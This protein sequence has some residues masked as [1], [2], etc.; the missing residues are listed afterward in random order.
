MATEDPTSARPPIVADVTSSRTAV[1]EGE[2]VSSSNMF[3]DLCLATSAS[4]D[5]SRTTERRL[6]GGNDV[7]HDHVASITC[8]PKEQGRETLDSS[9]PTR[10]GRRVPLAA[11]ALRAPTAALETRAPIKMRTFRGGLQTMSTHDPIERRVRG[12]VGEPWGRLMVG[13]VP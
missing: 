3:V 13:E 12:P 8:Q 6:P 9:F 10:Y 11:D 7:L 5:S 4:G 2:E 1:K